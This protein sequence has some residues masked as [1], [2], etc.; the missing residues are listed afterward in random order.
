MAD[1]GFERDIVHDVLEEANEIGRLSRTEKPFISAYEAFRS[2]DRKAFQAV[3]SRLRL[4]CHLICHWIRVKE[5]FFLC[6]HLAGPPPARA[7][8]A[9]PA[10]A[11]SGDRPPDL[12]RACPHP[13]RPRGREARPRR[14]PA[15]HQGEAARA[16]LPL[17]LPLGLRRPVRAPVPTGSASR[18]SASVRASSPSF[19]PAARRSP[20]CSSARRSSTRPSRRPTPATPRSSA[21]SSQRAGPLPVLPV[22]LS[23]GSAAG[24]A[25]SPASRSA[26][27]SRSRRSGTRSARRSSSARGRPSASPSNRPRPSSA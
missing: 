1:P 12:G 18:S 6:L 21:P 20:S 4:R 25:C 23:S 11:R 13:A 14:L 8:E 22:H 2:E 15:D 24:A 17:H 3:I 27:S 26:G 9:R 16:V 5:C 19:R 10:P 7:A